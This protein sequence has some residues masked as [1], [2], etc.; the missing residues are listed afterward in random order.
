MV[1]N[2]IEKTQAH[3]RIDLTPKETTQYQK[4]VGKL[5]LEVFKEIMGSDEYQNAVANPE[6]NMTAD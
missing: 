4:R 1:D 2:Y 6:K 5:T 3:P